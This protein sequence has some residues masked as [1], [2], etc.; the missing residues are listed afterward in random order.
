MTE[1]GEPTRTDPTRTDVPP[2]VVHGTRRFGKFH[3]ELIGCGLAG[4]QLLGTDVATV[5][6][7]DDLVVREPGDGLRW[8][9]CLRCDAWL[10]LPPPTN[11]SAQEL[12]NRDEI[13]LPLRGRP[14]RDRYVLRLIAVDRVVHFLVLG[15]LAVVVF[16]FVSKRAAYSDTFYKVLDAIQSALGGPDGFRGGGIVRE[17]TKAFA[18]KSTSLYVVGLVLA[19]YALLEGVEAVGLW[20]GKRWAE[21]LTFVATAVLLVPEIYE[22]TGKVTVAKII[23]LLIN[24]AVVAY[25]LYA[26]RLFGLRGGGRVEAEAHDHDTGW[27]A[28]ERTRPEA[29]LPS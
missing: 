13:E 17:L 22:L 15:A 7:S 16:L 10:P 1:R 25:L 3:Y 20:L 6:P 12:P 8:H 29:G 11:P 4:H 18:A 19:G 23:T 21:Y 9:R 2:G 27:Q 24:L 14:L 26:K 28:L 5:R